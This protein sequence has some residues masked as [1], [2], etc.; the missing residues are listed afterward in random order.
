MS[1]NEPNACRQYVAPNLQTAG[2]D[3]QPY[4]L[5]EQRSFTDGRIIV[6]GSK[7]LPG[8]RKRAN[9]LLY[10]RR[11]FPIAV[12]E[13]K[14]EDEPAMTGVQQARKYAESNTIILF[15]ERS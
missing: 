2:C 3:N 6:T 11:D 1:L 10:Y 7:V 12:A 14:A 5:G 9:Y 13:A 8:E 15:D 4:L